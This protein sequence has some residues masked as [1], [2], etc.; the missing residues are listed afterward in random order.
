MEE[1]REEIL[2]HLLEGGLI[3]STVGE[4]YS[5]RDNL[6]SFRFYL[7]LSPAGAES[8]EGMEGGSQF[9]RQKSPGRI[10]A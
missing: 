7:G 2:N 1:G 6:E 9:S 8:E 4:R 3:L 10:Y 5:L